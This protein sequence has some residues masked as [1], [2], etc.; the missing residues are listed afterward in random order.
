VSYV[1]LDLRRCTRVTF[2]KLPK[3]LQPR[4]QNVDSMRVLSNLAIRIEYRL[5]QLIVRREPYL[6]IRPE[7]AG[8]KSNRRPQRVGSERRADCEAERTGMLA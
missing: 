8:P 1:L 7:L 4:K 6:E 3:I 2:G 5:E